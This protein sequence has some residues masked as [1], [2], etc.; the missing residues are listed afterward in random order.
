MRSI[1]LDVGFGYTKAMVDNKAILFPS[2]ISPPVEIGFRSWWEDRSDRIN[3]LE[4][5]V[6]GKT[7]FVGNLA[8]NQGRFAYATLD[9]IRT[10]T[11]EYRLL[12]VAA[13]AQFVEFPE[14]EFSVVTGLPVD[15]FE[16]R[17]AIEGTFS[18]RF[19]LTVAGRQVSFVIRNL[20]VIPQPCGAFMDLLFPGTQGNLNEEYA[21]GLVGIVDI[22]YK[23]TDFVLMQSGEYAQ[24]LSGSLKH[25]VSTIYQAA[26][27]R[28]SAAYRGNWDLRSVEEALSYGV[29]SRLGE[30]TAINPALLDAEFA[31][32]AGQITSWIRQRWSDEGLHRII[33]T[34][35]GSL[36]L[37]PYL[38][39]ALPGITFMEDPQQANVRG[40]FKGARYYFG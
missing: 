11:K 6:D 19:D 39:K 15:D 36:M 34:G 22:G 27:S 18:G 37:E 5:T 35:G 28:F 4:V 29:I 26:I 12:F 7:Y 9:R 1:G 31:G 16:D 23:T 14:E 3:H 20:T 17:D 25:G 38:A 2:V 40:F 8:L 13:M 21:Q 32:L 33:C 10:Q 24:K 30:R